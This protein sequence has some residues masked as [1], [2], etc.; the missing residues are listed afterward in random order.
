MKRGDKTLICV[1]AALSLMG[2]VNAISDPSLNP[3]LGIVDRNVFGLKP[4]PPPPDP[5]ANKPPP[6]P[7]TLTG[8]TTILGNKRALM[9]TAPTVAKPGEPAK[10]QSYIL[11]IGQRDGDIEV[12]DIDEKAGSV[13]VRYA[14]TESTLTFD[15]NGP[16]IAATPLPAAPAIPVPAG[17]IPPPMAI[18]APAGSSPT[19]F[20]SFGAPT[21]GVTRPLRM[22]TQGAAM[23]PGYSYAGAV[24]AAGISA[25]GVTLPGFGAAPST[26]SQTSAPNITPEEQTIVMEVLR[27]KNKNNPNFPPFPPTS[28]TPQPS[29]PASSAGQAKQQQQQTSVM[30]PL[31]PGVSP[32][33]RPQ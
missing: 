30:P 7:I 31:P 27:E 29:E 14:G 9:K 26:I 8:I 32:A 13:K 24:P 4:P 16:K 10:E 17:A 22:P 2:P 20:P 28:L 5:E 6:P 25:G 21:P 15:K 12:L 11:T 3:Y 18:P 33:F 1:L 19:P 23:T